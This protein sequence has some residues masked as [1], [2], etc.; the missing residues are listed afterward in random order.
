MKFHDFELNSLQGKPVKL[1]AYKGHPVLV[2]NVASRCG[3]TPQ[4]KELQAMYDTLGPKGLKIVGVPCN[5]FG[6][7]EPGSASDIEQ[8]CTKNYGVSFD[9]MEKIHVNGSDAHPLYEKFLK[10]KDHNRFTPGNVQWN[11]QKYLISK[12]G[13]IAA[14]WGP[15]V[16]P[17]APE[18]V[19]AVEAALK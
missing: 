6:A 7:Q 5:D 1:S 16:K 14:A 17:N 3:L 15:Q 8:F 13:D 19:A 18:I 9:M 2:V 10:S 12:D 4:Y 11:F